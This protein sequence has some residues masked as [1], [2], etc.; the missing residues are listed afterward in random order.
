[1]VPTDTTRTVDTGLA[2][3]RD[4][5]SPRAALEVA[6]EFV[7]AAAHRS[8]D[9]FTDADGWRY[10]SDAY[11]CVTELEVLT[12]RLTPLL[13]RL[14]HAVMS[15]QEA[16]AVG[17]AFGSPYEGDPTGLVRTTSAALTAAAAAAQ[18]VDR[19]SAAQSALADAVHVD[20]PTGPELHVVRDGD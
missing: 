7:R 2:E 15:D 14:D 13:A 16:Q 6:A 17:V 12:G 5:G 4:D 20:P 19:L 9:R 1:M 11:D 10:P 8:A 18:L 3:V